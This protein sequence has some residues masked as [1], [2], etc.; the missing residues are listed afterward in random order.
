MSAEDRERSPCKKLQD[1]TANVQIPFQNRDSR[2]LKQL[3]R[4][5]E[6]LSR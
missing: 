2:D 4:V 1:A 5:L 3:V 6:G